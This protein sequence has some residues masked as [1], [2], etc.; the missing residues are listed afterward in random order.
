MLQVQ[1]FPG[2][3]VPETGTGKFSGTFPVDFQSVSERRA[4][5]GTCVYLCVF[6]SKFTGRV[7]FRMG[8]KW[9]F[10]GKVS[11][12]IPRHATLQYYWKKTHLI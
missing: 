12:R 11:T 3:Q 9:N 10:P 4:Y 8:A 1:S 5:M 2:S 7:N 6:L